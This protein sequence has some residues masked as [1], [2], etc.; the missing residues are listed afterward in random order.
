MDRAELLIEPIVLTWKYIY[1]FVDSS[2]HRQVGLA[3]SVDVRSAD[4]SRAGHGFLVDPGQKFLSPVLG[5]FWLTHANSQNTH[6]TP[7]K[8]SHYI[9]TFRGWQS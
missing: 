2:M 1:G 4:M 6:G 9:G 5:R 3:V 8:F 7:L